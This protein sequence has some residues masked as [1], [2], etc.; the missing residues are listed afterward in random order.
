MAAFFGLV[1]LG[2]LFCL[3]W[4]FRLDALYWGGAALS[5]VGLLLI[6]KALYDLAEEFKIMPGAKRLVTRGIY[7][8]VRHPTYIG[9]SLL[10]FGWAF[11]INSSVMS[12]IALGVTV[13]NAIRAYFE[14]KTLQKKFGKKYKE[15]RKRTWF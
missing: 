14:N 1:T 4:F 12:W 6:W 8:K 11:V 13:L 3:Y 10:L 7:S 2:F 9:L 15:Y 5:M